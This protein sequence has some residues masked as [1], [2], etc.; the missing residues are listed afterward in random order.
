MRLDLECFFF[1]QLTKRLGAARNHEGLRTIGRGG[2]WWRDSIY[3]AQR[4]E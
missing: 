3:C 4:H 1:G 2:R